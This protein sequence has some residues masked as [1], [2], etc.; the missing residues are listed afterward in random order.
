MEKPM[1]NLV[2]VICCYLCS[3]K[4]V[5]SGHAIESPPYR[6]VH[7]ESEF[8]LRLYKE[9]SWMSA[10]VQDTTSF[11]KATKDGFH[12]LYQYIHGANLNS[13]EITITAPVLTSIVPSVHGLAEYYVKLY[14]AAKYE[15]TPPQPSAELNLQLDNWRSHCI[16]VRKFPGFAK[17]DR[18]SKEYETLVDSLNKHLIGKP[19]ILAAESPYAI[20]QYNASYHLSGRLNE[21]WMD[22]SGITADC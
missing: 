11:E 17:D 10:L 1:L 22:L 3:S 9:S 16:A 18:F 12:R 21:V 13:S 20:A 2:I 6:V 19:A 15:G 5:L 4:L 8:E 7:S 14:L